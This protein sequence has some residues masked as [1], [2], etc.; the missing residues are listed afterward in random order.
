LDWLDAQSIIDTFGDWAVLAVVTIIFLET[1]F[2]FTSF[3][4]GDSLLFII[5]LTLSVGS[6]VIPDWLGFILIWLAAF[7]GTQLGWYVGYKI[8]PPL[9]ERRENIIFNKKVVDTTR[10]FFDKYGV[11]AIILARFVPIIRALV[12]MFAGISKVEFGRFTRLNAIGATLWLAV[13]MVPGYFLGNLPLVKENLETAVL[14]VIIV[15]SLPFPLEI[16]RTVIQNRRAKKKQEKL[17]AEY[18]IAE[19]YTDPEKL[20]KKD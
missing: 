8:G 4:P 6:G 3:L 12:P 13:F 14:I 20:P 1:A 2:I 15:S 16:L 19:G 5:G 17:D 10:K 11:R 7:G 9:F 18:E